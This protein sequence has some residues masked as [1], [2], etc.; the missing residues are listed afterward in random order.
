SAVGNALRAES[1][2]APEASP[3]A[4]LSAVPSATAPALSAPRPAPAAAPAIRLARFEDLVALAGERR[5][6]TMKAALERDVRLVRFEDG[7]LEFALAEGARR[8]LANEISRKLLEWTGRR[9]MVALSSEEG[10]TP[11]AEVALAAAQER[12]R[13]AAAHPLVREVLS[14]FPGAQI[15]DVRE[16][17]GEGAE[18]EADPVAAVGLEPAALPPI[19]DDDDPSL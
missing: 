11:L 5:D 14:R 13:D 18:I 9:W 19:E 1:A 16:R 17:A 8:D 4:H 7:R 10:A 6:I 3:R 12:R 2:P 15:V